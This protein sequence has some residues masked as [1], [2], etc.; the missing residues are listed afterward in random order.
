[1]KKDGHSS[2]LE[3]GEELVCLTQFD[4]HESTEIG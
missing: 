4:V 2:G 1:M 3:V